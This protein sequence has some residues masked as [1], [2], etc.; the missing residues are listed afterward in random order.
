MNLWRMYKGWFGKKGRASPAPTGILIIMVVILLAGCGGEDPT[1][2]GDPAILTGPNALPKQIATIVL[3][4]TPTDVLGGGQMVNVAVQP[5]ITA[6]PPQPT[7]TLTPYVG[8]FLGQP[9]S[10][11]GEGGEDT[12]PTLA[13]YVIN[14]MAGAPGVGGSIPSASGSCTVP[15]AAALANAYNANATVQQRLGCP[16]DGG[17]TAQMATQP[18]E[19]GTMYWRNTGQIYALAS[20]GQFWQITDSWTEGMPS[21]DPAYSSPPSGLI[22]PVRGFGL[23][24]RNNAPIRDALGWATLPEAPFTS[25]WQNFERG[26][27]FVG[28]N[29]MIFAIY[30]SEGQYSG[31]LSP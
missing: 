11:S 20:N 17:S 18:F 22:Q 27:L 15:A 10:E 2:E 29:N 5:T 25:T 6:G 4:P 8:I 28:A 14:P 3:T 13:P 24:W 26:A 7:P 1:P 23:A 12:I 31:P 21:D 9:T 19:R 30:T 16:V